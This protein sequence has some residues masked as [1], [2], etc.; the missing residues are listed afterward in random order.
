MLKYHYE[1]L[2]VK[3]SVIF[4]NAFFIYLTFEIEAKN[5]NSRINESLIVY[6]ITHLTIYRVHNGRTGICRQPFGPISSD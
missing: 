4:K 6:N 3:L 5:K 1:E 2:T